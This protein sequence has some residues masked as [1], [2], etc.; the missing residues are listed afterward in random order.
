MLIEISKAYR[1]SFDALPRTYSKSQ[2]E[3]IRKV[4]KLISDKKIQIGDYDNHH[5]GKLKVAKIDAFDCHPLYYDNHKIDLIIL[6]GYGRKQK[7]V[8]FYDIG[9]HKQVLAKY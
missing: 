4:M 8:I 5:L 3:I 1:E 6:Y 7:R 2:L 9:T